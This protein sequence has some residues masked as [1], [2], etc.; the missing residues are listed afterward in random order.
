MLFNGWAPVARAV[1]FSLA[2]YLAVVTLI[3]L[4][5]KRTIAKLNPGDFAIVVA[6]GSVTASLILSADV[7]LVEGLAAIGALIG[8]QFG[9]ERLTSRSE[10]LRRLAD[11][12]AVLLVHRGVV[13]HDV[14][15]RENVDEDDILAAARERGIGRVADLHAVVL[16]VDGSFSVIPAWHAGDDTLKD[17]ARHRKTA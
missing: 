8:L 7:S 3:R 2:A 1:L 15:Q 17:V 5:G 12:E 16:E 10:K 4:A 14:L 11:G 9:T 13:F 6:I